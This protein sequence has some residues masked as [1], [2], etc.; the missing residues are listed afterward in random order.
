MYHDD[1]SNLRGYIKLGLLPVYTI[2]NVLITHTPVDI[3][4]VRSV[5]EIKRDTL[6]A[7][8]HR[9]RG[10]LKKLINQK[11]KAAS[12]SGLARA[13]MYQASI[14]SQ[15]LQRAETFQS[16]IGA[17]RTENPTPLPVSLTGERDPFIA[18]RD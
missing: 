2:N 9:T 17:T 13:G 12:D 16:S 7:A 3:I 10:S 14:N 8:S 18:L 11:E 6:H 15:E 5:C 4:A 1:S